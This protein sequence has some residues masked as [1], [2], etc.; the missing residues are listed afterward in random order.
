MPS[1]SRAV[2]R[3]IAPALSCMPLGIRRDLLRRAAL[4]PP[5]FKT[6]NFERLFARISD[7]GMDREQLIET[8]FGLAPHIRCR[9][10]LHKAQYA[11]VDLRTVQWSA[12]QSL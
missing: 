6:R 3:L 5:F 8:N 4:A 12:V 9:V 10:P 11:L 1:T 2:K 7:N